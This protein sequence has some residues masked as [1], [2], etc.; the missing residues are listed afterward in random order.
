MLLQCQGLSS[1][2]DLQCVRMRICCRAGSLDFF[3]N[4]PHNT[5][6]FM[7]GRQNGSR[8]KE[9]KKLIKSQMH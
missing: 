3:H 5:L 7:F 6:Y 4:V 2:T 8:D 1:Q 9:A